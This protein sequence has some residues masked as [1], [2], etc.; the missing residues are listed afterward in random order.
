MCCPR[1]FYFPPFWALDTEIYTPLVCPPAKAQ[2]RDMS[3]LRAFG[4]LK[5]GVSWEQA[6]VDM[7]T[8]ARSL[9]QEYPRS[10]AERKRSSD[11]PA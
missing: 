7:R 8:I 3:T 5:P 4:R 1:T 6:A 9:A 11:A 2:S 10:N